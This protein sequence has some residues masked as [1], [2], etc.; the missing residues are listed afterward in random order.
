MG[1]ALN[2]VVIY[3]VDAAHAN[4]FT[5]DAHEVAFAETAEAGKLRNGQFILNMLRYV[6]EYI[7]YLLTPG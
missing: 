5:K 3:I 6:L 4:V 7:F 2:T 1:G